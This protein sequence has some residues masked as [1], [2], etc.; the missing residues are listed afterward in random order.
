MRQGKQSYNAGGRE[1]ARIR[2]ERRKR[3]ELYVAQIEKKK[4]EKE[5]STYLGEKSTIKFLR[6][7]DSTHQSAE[8]YGGER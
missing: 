3:K 8:R 5:D 7:K 6:V 2:D 4:G 1:T